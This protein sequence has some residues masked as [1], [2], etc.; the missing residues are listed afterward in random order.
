[1]ERLGARVARRYGARARA[2]NTARVKN[3]RGRGLC[4]QRYNN[5]MQTQPARPPIT[6]AS[7][8]SQAPLPSTRGA[9]C[10]ARM[11]PARR[12]GSCRDGM[13]R[14]VSGECAHKSHTPPRQYP[15]ALRP[16]KHKL[17]IV[18]FVRHRFSSGCSIGCN[19]CDGTTRGCAPRLRAVRPVQNPVSSGRGSPVLSTT[20]FRKRLAVDRPEGLPPVAMAA[21]G[22]IL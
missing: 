9:L 13:A 6:R 3:T 1:M 17:S 16:H 8:R 4:V 21:R 18:T 2:K 10:P 7:A 20:R 5:V 12:R 14:R 22:C 11:L 19:K 15:C